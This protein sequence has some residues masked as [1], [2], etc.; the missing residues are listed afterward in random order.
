VSEGVLTLRELNRDVTRKVETLALRM[1]E[2]ASYFMYRG[3][4]TQ[5]TTGSCSA[6]NMAD[7]PVSGAVFVSNGPGLT[8]DIAE[9]RARARLWDDGAEAGELVAA[10]PPHELARDGGEWAFVFEIKGRH[11]DERHSHT[12]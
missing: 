2:P 6:G 3:F 12:G 4:R 1:A 11:L 5:A 7:K 8:P 10:L 9:A